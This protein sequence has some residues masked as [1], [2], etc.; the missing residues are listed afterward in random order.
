MH[1]RELQFRSHFYEFLRK[2]AVRHLDQAKK[3]YHSLE[4]LRTVVCGGNVVNDRTLRFVTRPDCRRHV[5]V[6]R[7]FILCCDTSEMTLVFCIVDGVSLSQ[8]IFSQ[9]SRRTIFKCVSDLGAGIDQTVPRRS[10]AVGAHGARR[11]TSRASEGGSD[12]DDEGDG[13]GASAPFGDSA[14]HDDASDS[15]ETEEWHGAASKP[16]SGLRAVSGSLRSGHA[17]VNPDFVVTANLRMRRNLGSPYSVLRRQHGNNGSEFSAS[18][19][20]SKDTT[21]T[22][23]GYL[24]ELTAWTTARRPVK[25]QQATQLIAP[26]SSVVTDI[27]FQVAAHDLKFFRQRIFNDAIFGANTTQHALGATLRRREDPTTAQTAKTLSKNLL[28]FQSAVQALRRV[29]DPGSR[30]CS[31][32]VR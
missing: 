14:L 22:L 11:S 30:F 18:H 15:E 20:R 19:S 29:A 17:R 6:L 3:A 9:Q 2:R 10:A 28:V 16:Q 1:S 24:A 8:L 31:T 23:Q 27:F 5:F 4:I 12:G 7:G 13:E 21:I 32:V 26:V 25:A